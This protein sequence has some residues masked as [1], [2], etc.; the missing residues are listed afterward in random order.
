MSVRMLDMMKLWECQSKGFARYRKRSTGVEVEEVEHLPQL[1]V[2]G[3]R[4]QLGANAA[5]HLLRCPPIDRR[6]HV[7]QVAVVAVQLQS[8]VAAL[9]GD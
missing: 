2:V 7:E 3:H 6:V 1:F 8:L 5:A 9:G 4:G